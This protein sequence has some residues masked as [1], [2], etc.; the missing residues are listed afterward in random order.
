MNAIATPL[1]LV[2]NNCAD[3]ITTQPTNQSGAKGTNKNFSFTYSGS[4][5]NY[6]WQSNPIG[7]GW[8]NVP[9]NNQYLGI[10][11]TALTVNNVNVSNHN[12]RFRVIASKSGCADT[13]NI[14]SLIV[15]DIASDSINLISLKADTTSKGNRI[16][17]LETDLANKH[18]T[19]YVGSNITTDTLKI[20]IR[21]GLTLASPLLNS[22]KVYP[23]PAATVLH[24]DL[25]KPG[26]YIARL[27]GVTGQTVV[28]PTSGTID[29]S[30]L[31]NGVYILT[32][33]DSNNKLISTNKI[34]IVK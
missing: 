13:S 23:N 5:Y 32:I 30:S 2:T 8:Q 28:S 33:Y 10:T 34:L 31:A 7:F 24:I 11:T 16:R 4:G 14:V 6:Q 26:N 25:E 12:Q 20:S 15:S 21:T 22:I 19:L 9:I 17:Q 3:S 18:D 1:R 29:I 27:T